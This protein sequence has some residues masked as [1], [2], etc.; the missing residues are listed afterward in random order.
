MSWA[1]EGWSNPISQLV[2]PAVAAGRVG[3]ADARRLAAAL[4]LVIA[5]LP[6]LAT[7]MARDLAGVAWRGAADPSLFPLAMNASIAPEIAR[8]SLSADGS[9]PIDDDRQLRDACAPLWFRSCDWV[10][11]F[12][13]RLVAQRAELVATRNGLAAVGAR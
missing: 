7:Q 13:R 5:E 4:D 10:V 2:D 9:D 11:D 8:L 6:P 3:P 1:G 12:R